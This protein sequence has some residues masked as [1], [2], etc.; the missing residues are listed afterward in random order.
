VFNYSCTQDTGTCSGINDSS[1]AW[2]CTFP[3]WYIAES[4]DGTGVATDPIYF[5]QNWLAS[6][7]AG[8]NNYA[9]SSLVE[10]SSGNELTSLLA[11]DVTTSTIPYGGLQPG[12]QNDPISVETIIRALGNVGLDQTLY[13]AAMCTTYPTCGGAAT[14]TI[15]VGEQRYA[16]SSVTYAQGTALLANPGAELEINVQKSSATASPAQGTTTWGIRVPGAIT[17]AGSYY[18]QNT[19]IGITGES[20]N[21]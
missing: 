21:W 12:Q 15:P 16:T 8:D 9:T 20:A 2:T 18:G 17:L 7:Q 14:N 5:A 13:G 11:Y 10:A 3:L 6:V 19:L 1:A 4:T